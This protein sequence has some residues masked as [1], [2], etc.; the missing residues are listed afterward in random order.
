MRSLRKEGLSAH[1]LGMDKLIILGIIAMSL[2]FVSAQTTYS[3]CEVYGNCA[4]INTNSYNVYNN[5]SVENNITNYQNTSELDPVCTAWINANDSAWRSTYNSTYD[6]KVSSQWTTTGNSVYYLTGSVGIGTGKPLTASGFALEVNSTDANNEVLIH[7]LTKGVRIGAST[8]QGTIQAVDNTGTAS[9]QPLQVTGAN[10]SF[11]TSTT[12]RMFLKS[13]GLSI[14]VPVSVT[15]TSANSIVSSGRVTAGTDFVLSRTTTE[16]TSSVIGFNGINKCQWNGTGAYYCYALQMESR[17]TISTGNNNTG[18]AIGVFVNAL[19]NYDTAVTDDNGTLTELDGFRTHF[20]TY[21]SIAKA[22]PNITN[23]YGMTLYPYTLTGNITNLYDLYLKTKNGAVAQIQ[24][25]FGIYQ[26]DANAKNYFAGDVGIGTTTPNNALEVVGSVN[27]TNNLTTWGLL[28]VYGN[29][30]TWNALHLT[31]TQTGRTSADGMFVGQ[32][33]SSTAGYV[34]QNEANSLFFQVGGR[35]RMTITKDGYVGINTTAP[36]Y[37]LE[38]NMNVSEISIY[39][40]ANISAGGYITRTDVYDSKLGSALDKIKD[41]SQYFNAD[42]SINHQAFGYSY[43]GYDH[44]ITEVDENGNEI[45][46]KIM[47]EE[48]VDLGKEVA[49]IKQALYELKSCI[50]NSK[51]Y[52]EAKLCV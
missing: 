36:S 25:Y 40:Q 44:P 52:E 45:S 3:N 11:T 51:D 20:G 38:V 31:T 41:S 48:G 17:P 2:P 10:I 43:V 16:S 26:E 35:T 34:T 5:V 8:T 14:G 37:P 6:A 42:G 32:W 12:E 29:S 50:A 23:L 33:G 30:T 7:G 39:A 19:R 21:N 4:P 1:Y 28:R 9:Y 22:S 13:T 47:K 24:N 49:L 15:D 46:T 27:V 18:T